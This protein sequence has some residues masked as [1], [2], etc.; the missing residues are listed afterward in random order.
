MTDNIE[1][2]ARTHAKEVLDHTET[3]ADDDTDIETVVTVGHPGKAIVAM[4]GD[5]DAIVMGSHGSSLAQR[6]FIGDI[7]QPVFRHP[8]VPVTTVR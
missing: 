4:A 1:E 3:I 8:P 7:A 2:A 5:Y 6:L